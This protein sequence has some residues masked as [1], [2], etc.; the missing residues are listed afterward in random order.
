MTLYVLFKN[1]IFNVY[2]LAPPLNSSVNLGQKIY[3]SAFYTIKICY[4]PEGNRLGQMI[5]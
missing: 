3:L 2:Q 5:S 4:M 1:C